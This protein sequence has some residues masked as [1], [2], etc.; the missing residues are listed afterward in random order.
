MQKTESPKNKMIVGSMGTTFEM[1]NGLADSIHHGETAENA[2]FNQ[3]SRN[4][5][6]IQMN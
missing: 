4:G 5:S 6:I 2:E 3:D 1:P